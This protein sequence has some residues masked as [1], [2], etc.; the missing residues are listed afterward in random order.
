MVAPPRW[1]SGECV[2]PMTWWLRLQSPVEAAF[3]SSV[4]LPL[5]KHV[6]KV[7]G[8]FGKKS[9]VSTGV[10]KPGNTC[11]TDRHDMTSAVKVVLNPNTTNQPT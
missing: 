5:Q 1:L 4:F 6:R 9:C 10:R 7:V 3:L 11:I 2:G 8:G